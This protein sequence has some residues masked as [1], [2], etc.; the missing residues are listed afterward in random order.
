M[1]D[2]QD[3]LHVLQWN[4][5]ELTQSKRTEL[6]K[7]LNYKK[8]D[9]FTI[10]EANRVKKNIVRFIFPGYN[11]FIVEKGKKIA[12]GILVGVKNIIT[13]RFE[14]IKS[15]FEANDKIEIT[16]LHC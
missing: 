14:I 12:C 16:L 13:S 1:K 3:S 10:K 5:G 15:T 2:S 11:N 6:I 9:V 7:I 8:I 4:T